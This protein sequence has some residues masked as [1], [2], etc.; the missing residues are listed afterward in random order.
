[1]IK[2]QGSNGEFEARGEP[3]ARVS[4]GLG[5][6]KGSSMAVLVCRGELKKRLVLSR[7][8]K[9]APTLSKTKEIGIRKLLCSPFKS[10]DA[11]DLVALEATSIER[12][13]I[14]EPQQMSVECTASARQGNI[15]QG[16][17]MSCHAMPCHVMSCHVGKQLIAKIQAW[18][19]P[20][21]T[22]TGLD[23]PSR[24]CPSGKKQNV[25][26]DDARIEG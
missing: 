16:K 17:A 20:Y 11:S 15:G 3:D 21:G 24:K 6:R 14:L 25:P 22:G 7:G 5:S 12:S 13:M 9:M 4:I 2:K 23:A 26:A 1:M 8:G 10:S 18:I 19:V